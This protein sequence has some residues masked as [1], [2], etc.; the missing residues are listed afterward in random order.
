MASVWF[1]KG[2]QHLLQGDVTGGLDAATIKAVALTAGY[3]MDQTDEVLG[4]LGTVVA[5]SE[6]LTNSAITIGTGN[7]VLWGADTVSFVSVAAGTAI[8]Q[9]AY[10]WESGV[11]GTK[12]LLAKDDLAAPVTPDGSNINVSH[13]A[14]GIA[15]IEQPA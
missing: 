12:Y 9:I 5:T 10:Y 3:T 11:A 8:S 1:A 4:D 14:D 7:K 6:A 13:D 2:L 15:Q